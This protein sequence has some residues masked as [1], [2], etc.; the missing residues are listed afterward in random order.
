MIFKNNDQNTV[1]D[2][3]EFGK[4]VYLKCE[5]SLSKL[6]P[7]FKDPYKITGYTN[8]ETKTVLEPKTISYTAQMLYRIAW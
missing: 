7:I 2:K 5:G 6:G 3:I 8:V 1:S 4:T